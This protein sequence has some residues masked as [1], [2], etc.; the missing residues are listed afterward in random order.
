MNGDPN[1]P[2]SE[3]QFQQFTMRKDTLEGANTMGTQGE[4][5]EKERI[6]YFERAVTSTLRGQNFALDL[7][8]LMMKPT[9]PVQ[10]GLCREF[11]E[12]QIDLDLEWVNLNPKSKEL[13]F[14]PLGR[15]KRWRKT[16]KAACPK[17]T[18]IKSQLSHPKTTVKPFYRPEKIGLGLQ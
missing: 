17:Q 9:R 4:E 5:L 10:D 12:N 14:Q 2:T 6:V 8:V 3:M 13:G 18:M 1:P 11:S 16:G 7:L 15:P